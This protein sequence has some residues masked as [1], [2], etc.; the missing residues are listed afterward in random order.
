MKL[1]TWDLQSY[2]YVVPNVNLFYDTGNGLTNDRKSIKA[3]SSMA[4][5]Y[6]IAMNKIDVYSIIKAKL[7]LKI[8]KTIAFVC[9]HQSS[10]ELCK[11]KVNN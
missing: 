9:Y 2:A 5:Q 7:L 1:G 11:S 4:N 6:V 8:R 10:H 3:T